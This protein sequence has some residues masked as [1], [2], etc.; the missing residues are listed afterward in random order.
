MAS[1]FLSFLQNADALAFLLLGVF[2]AVS[3]LRHRSTS[4]GFLALAIVLLSLVSLLGRIPASYRP[5]FLSQISLLVF[6][7]SGYALLRFRGSLIPLSRQWHILAIIFIVATSILYLVLQALVARHLLPLDIQT[8]AGGL[9]VLVWSATV[10]EPILRF[11]L[12]ARSLPAVQAWRLRLLSLGFGGLVLILLVAVL[13]SSFA[14]D[15]A[16]QI[17]IQIAVLAIVPLLYVSFSPP[18]WLRH[19]WRAS[20]EQDLRSFMQDLALLAR[21][22]AA[23]ASQALEWAMRLVGGTAAVAFDG[24]GVQLA[25]SGIADAQLSDLKRLLPELYEG[26]SQVVIAGTERTLLALSIAST[27]PKGRLI[28]L[29]G[30]FTPSFGASELVRAQQFM[31]AVAAALERARLLEQLKSANVELLEA[32]RHKSIFLANMSHELRTPLNAILGFSQL[33]IDEIP[34]QID[35]ATRLSF[36]RHVSSSGQHLLDLINDILDLSKVEAGQMELR[37]SRTSITAVIESVISILE[38]LS[39]VKNIRMTNLSD[40]TLYLVADSGKL[41]QMLLNLVSNGIKFTPEGGSVTLSARRDEAFI[42]IAVTDTGIGIATNELPLLFQEFRQL[43]ASPSREQ[44]GTGL[45]LALTKRFAE[46]HGGSISVVST[47]GVGSTFTLRLPLALPQLI[48]PIPIPL[49]S[50]L[51]RPLILVVED[52]PAAAELLTRHLDAGGFRVEFASTG[53]EALSKANALQPSAITLDILLPEID[54]WEVLRRLKQNEA[55]RHIPVV[56]VSVVDNLE[57]ARALGAIDFLVKPVNPQDLL[58]RLAS[59]ALATGVPSDQTRVLVID[60]EVSQ[61]DL[62]ESFLKPAGFTVLRATAGQEGIAMTRSYKPDIIILDLRMPDVN[63]FDVVAALRFDETTKQ[64]P[65]IIFTSKQLTATDRTQLS[66]NVAAIFERDSTTN[67]EL[68]GWLR[69]QVGLK[70]SQ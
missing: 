40:P 51:S 35:P 15:P 25:S 7:G 14:S 38:P 47:K 5:P 45:G 55:T 52:N 41:K 16:I 62:L 24:A 22:P 2:T 66:G 68:I 10:L 23:L 19:L 64:I 44:E 28:V 1:A 9:L 60:D 37:P 26:V 54:G 42:E 56:I 30:P 33:M 31:N 53:P 46:L 48:E 3:W 21:D 67:A 36:L 58:T 20:E 59:H 27:G 17:L 12:V 70:E 18:A 13:V 50:D 63:G 8:L 69:R 4:L 61:L 11:Q 6:M 34:G 29:A 43:D 39:T 65:I 57:L 49:T 32:N